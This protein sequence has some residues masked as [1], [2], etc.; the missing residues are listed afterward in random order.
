MMR[1]RVSR[2]VLMA[3][4]LAAGLALSGCIPYSVGTTAQPVEQG[5]LVAS[6]TFSYV[7]S[8]VGFE[9]GD[10][11][12]NVGY[13]LPIVGARYGIDSASDLGLR[14]PGLGGFV[15]DYKRR[16]AGDSL[17]RTAALAVLGGAGIVNGGNHGYAEASVLVSGPEAGRT[18]VPYGG[19]RAMHVV[20]LNNSA[21]T[22][23][24]TLGGFVGVRIGSTR[25]GISPEIGV[26]YDSPALGLRD[27][28]VIVV[29]AI[30]LHGRGLFD[31]FG[32]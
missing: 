19:V 1:F 13:P 5:E 7:P 3:P 6:N 16:L 15:L 31:I 17:G 27:H 10:T 26:F 32:P 29:P 20:P 22:D 23:R 30:T 12:E 9:E 28:D 21:V 4:L 14:A 24:P 11:D 8:G 2:F 25:L 18:F